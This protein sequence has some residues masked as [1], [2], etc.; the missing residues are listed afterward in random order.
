M[1][2]SEEDVPLIVEA[3][4][5]AASGRFQAR[6]GTVRDVLAVAF[7]LI[8]VASGHALRLF[9][10]RVMLSHYAAASLN[11]SL[12]A[13]ISSFGMLCFFLG[14]A[15]YA[16]TFV[17]QYTG[18]G[19]PERVGLAVWQAV[20]VALIGGMLVAAAG[21]LAEP[22]FTWYGH[23]P[24]VQQQEAIYFR[25][26]NAFAVFPL[27][28]T[29]ALSFWSGRGLTWTVM[30]I[31]VPMSA[32]NILFN[33]LLIFGVGP[34]PRLG[35]FGAGLATGLASALGCIVGLGL[36]LRRTNRERFGTFPR[37]TFDA[38]L[39]RRLVHFGLPNAV[40]FFLD[41]ASFNLFIMLIGRLGPLAQEA[42]T[43]AFSV[44][45]MVFI[46]MIGLGMAV[47]VLVGQAVGA[48]RI[49]RARRAVR[50]AAKL[51]GLYFGG[52]LV[53]ILCAP[54]L[55]ID[56]FGREGGAG[57]A[58]AMDLAY[59][60]LHFIA[61]YVLFHGLWVLFNHALKGAGDTRFTM[62]AGIGLGWGALALPAFAIYHGFARQPGTDPIDA[63]WLFWGLLVVYVF[64]SFLVFAFRYRGGKWQRMR[65]IEEEPAPAGP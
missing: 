49:P 27:V 32:A 25:T 10:D 57:Q 15:G 11:A 31:E 6:R 4:P 5:P 52:G 8:C 56:I 24:A 36:L 17:A 43:M 42:S 3:P 2:E 65:V 35:I 59:T 28:L 38:P 23:A 58:A 20:Y 39:F 26:L 44:N 21:F 63:L 47:M 34:F 9:V 16:N 54:G 41:L 13:G 53:L 30:A 40:H 45:A 22:L 48:R 61:L 18:A 60:L 62:W 50:S 37:R 46:P 12:S 1:Y 51:V 64:L 55:F 29:A 33:W 14:L 7:P 19:R